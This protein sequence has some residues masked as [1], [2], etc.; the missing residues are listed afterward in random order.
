MDRFLLPKD[1]AKQIRDSEKAADE[2]ASDRLKAEREA[3]KQRRVDLIA[4]WGLPEK[5]PPHIGRPRYQH[6][7][8]MGL[9]QML[10]QVVN[11]KMEEPSEVHLR[12]PLTFGY[13][14]ATP[15]AVVQHHAEVP[16]LGARMT[17]CS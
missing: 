7:W 5:P 2:V 11:E 6:I 4:K 14:S 8:N 1:V 17:C 12:P 13:P 16:S 3:V 15:L 10:D 9:W